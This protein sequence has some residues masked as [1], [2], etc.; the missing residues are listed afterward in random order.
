VGFASFENTL[1]TLTVRSEHYQCVWNAARIADNRAFPGGISEYMFLPADASWPPRGSK[2]CEPWDPEL[3]SGD[4]SLPVLPLQNT[5][6][7]TSPRRVMINTEAH[8]LSY[9]YNGEFAGVDRED[10]SV[11]QRVVVRYVRR[12]P[13]V[14]LPTAHSMLR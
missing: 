10:V 3:D 12:M 5:V 1:I 11:S 9:E 6:S 7:G 2:A 8:V 4:V 13:I 14:S